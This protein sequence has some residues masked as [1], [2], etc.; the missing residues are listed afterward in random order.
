MGKNISFF[1]IGEDGYFRIIR[2]E[3]KCGINK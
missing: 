3:G 2:G 1:L